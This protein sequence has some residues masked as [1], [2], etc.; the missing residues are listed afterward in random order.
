LDGG[1][2]YFTV[3]GVSLGGVSYG[4]AFR[5]AT[6]SSISSGVRWL[7]LPCLSSLLHVV[8]T[9]RSVF[10]LPWCR[11]GAVRYTPSS[12]GVSYFGPIVSDGSSPLVPTSWTR[13]G[14]SG[15]ESV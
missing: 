13:N 3:F 9:S 14:R 2:R 12:V 7:V 15:R 5:N 8:S 4:S 10:A 1:T 6:N 11:Y